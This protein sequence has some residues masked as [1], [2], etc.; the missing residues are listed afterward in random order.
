M[1]NPLSAIGYPLVATKDATVVDCS[2]GDKTDFVIFTGA[3]W[4]LPPTIWKP[5]DN[6]TFILKD[7][8]GNPLF[9]P[10]GVLDYAGAFSMP[11]FWCPNGCKIT[12]SGFTGGN[13]TAWYKRT[14]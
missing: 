1:G 14:L 11:I 6:A 3:A 13:L 9:G 4:L 7:A 8:D 10:G 12:T 2:T 5:V